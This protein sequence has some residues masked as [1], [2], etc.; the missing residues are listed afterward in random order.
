MDITSFIIYLTTTIILIEFLAHVWLTIDI[1]KKVPSA[2]KPPLI[3]ACIPGLIVLIYSFLTWVGFIKITL[4][5]DIMIITRC[6]FMLLV[7]SP[8]WIL[9]A[10]ANLP[11]VDCVYGIERRRKG[12]KKT[13]PG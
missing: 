5:L 7:G 13:I 9:F 4:S 1:L 2:S 8:S 3:M 10:L 12:W 11:C 6:T